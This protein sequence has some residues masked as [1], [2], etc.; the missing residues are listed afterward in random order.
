MKYSRQR[1]LIRETLSH[2]KPHPT[3]DEIYTQ[4]K[5]VLPDLSLGT[6]YRN[7]GQLVERGEAIKL[8]MPG[9]SDR[10]DAT[11]HEHGHI[12]CIVCGRIYDCALPS[13]A[14]FDRAV[15]AETGVTVQSHH[16]L[17]TGVCA[18]CAAREAEAERKHA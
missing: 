3:A 8:T 17:L 1:E 4:L 12:L 5:P 18:D 6:V 13:L 9:R 14:A 10:F 7:L 2:G 11:L 16:V 15:E